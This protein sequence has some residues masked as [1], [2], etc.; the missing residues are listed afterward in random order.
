MTD[1]QILVRQTSNPSML[2]ML[3]RLHEDVVA[4][5]RQALELKSER[6]YYKAEADRHNAAANDLAKR[7]AHWIEKHDALLE[8]QLKNDNCPPTTLVV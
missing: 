5:G 3:Q 2:K 7:C 6:D 1:L 8:S 4:L